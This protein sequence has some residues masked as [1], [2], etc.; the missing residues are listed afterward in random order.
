MSAVIFLSCKVDFGAIHAASLLELSAVVED[1]VLARGRDVMRL[2]ECKGTLLTGGMTGNERIDGP[3]ANAAE[4][5][6]EG[7]GTEGGGP[8]DNL[9]DDE[10]ARCKGAGRFIADAFGNAL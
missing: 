9:S 2:L 4:G 6:G 1:K 7:R 10:N 3:I 8:L 5:G